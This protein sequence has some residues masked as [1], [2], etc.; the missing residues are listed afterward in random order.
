VRLHP[1]ESQAAEEGNAARRLLVTV[2]QRTARQ[3]A[4]DDDP[5]EPTAFLPLDACAHPGLFSAVYDAQAACRRGDI[6]PDER[7]RL[8]L[9]LEDAVREAACG[10]VRSA[11]SPCPVWAVDLATPQPHLR[12]SLAR[13]VAQVPH[14]PDRVEALA[15]LRVV[16]W[17]DADRTSF[18]AASCLLAEVWPP[19]LAE[20]RAVVHQIALLDGFGIDGF[21]D[22]ATHGAVYVNRARLEP[23]ESGLPGAVRMAEA[24]VHEG[25][26]NRCNAAALI[27]PLLEADCGSEPVVQTPL[28]QD[29]RPLTGL[30][31]QLV[32]LVRSVLLFDRLLARPGLSEAE[33]AAVGARRDT[34]R[35]QADD[36]LRLVGAHTGLLSD[37]GRALVADAERLL[38]A[39]DVAGDL[40]AT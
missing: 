1:D 18:C 30:L 6:A 20:L 26:H 36:A 9:R 13:A 23:G 5:T 22:V 3:L 4:G 8:A 37:H 21:T 28:R 25:A 14:R 7:R 17:S 2:L 33:S 10:D 12:E 27:H 15:A 40:A 35:H 29:L 38:P 32:V 19:M 24:L 11:A 31:Q 16:A 39:G 34:L